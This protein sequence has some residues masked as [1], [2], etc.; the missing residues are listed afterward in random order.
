MVQDKCWPDVED[1]GFVVSVA[2]RKAKN[3]LTLFPWQRK[4]QLL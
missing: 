2:H 4:R 3:R 1:S